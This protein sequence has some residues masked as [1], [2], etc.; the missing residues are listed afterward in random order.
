MKNRENN[1]E[2]QTY[3]MFFEKLCKFKPNILEES[4]FLI[5]RWNFKERKMGERYVLVCSKDN[6]RKKELEDWG[7]GVPKPPEGIPSMIQLMVDNKK[8]F[9]IKLTKENG[10]ITWEKWE[11]DIKLTE[12]NGIIRWERQEKGKRSENM[13]ASKLFE[14]ELAKYDDQVKTGFQGYL[15]AVSKYLL[16][17]S[18]DINY[19]YICGIEGPTESDRVIGAFVGFT[20]SDI[21]DQIDIIKTYLKGIMCDYHFRELDEIKTSHALRS[22]VAAIM[23]RNMSH[24]I[25]SHVLN[26]LSNPE[27]LDKL[28]II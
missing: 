22:A 27:E 13:N 12:K 8:I 25:G 21:K 16:N 3:Q 6:Q 19:G 24:N 20:K 7:N 15:K 23:A 1:E 9:N 18:L 14:E 28:W 4:V 5:V 10:I 26:Y 11:E 17:N 2:K